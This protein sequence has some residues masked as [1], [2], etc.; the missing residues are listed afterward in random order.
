MTP[1]EL[2]VVWMEYVIRHKGA[3][4]LKPHAFN[5]NWYQYFMLDVMCTV[6]INVFLV[7]FV[8]RTVF[9][10]TLK[11]LHNNYKVKTR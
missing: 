3:P 5:L 4:H 6:V 8:T 2:I 7:L 1:A 9:K 11:Y 10:T